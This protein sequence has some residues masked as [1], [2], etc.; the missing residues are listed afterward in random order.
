MGQLAIKIKGCW[1]LSLC[2]LATMY[3]CDICEKKFA[4]KFGLSSHIKSRV[5][6]SCDL[7]G[8]ELCNKRH[9]FMHTFF[10]HKAESNK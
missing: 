6:S 8:L 3:K 2:D 5:K 1:P 10:A 7:C 4:S 9:K